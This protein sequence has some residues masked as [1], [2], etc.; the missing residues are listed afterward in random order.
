M[1]GKISKIK[2]TKGELALPVTTVEAVYLE[3]GKT[4]LSDEIKDVLKYEVIDDEGITA[5]I[6]SVIEEIDGIKK[7]IS[8]INSSLDTIETKKANK[9]DVIKKGQVDLDEMTERTLQAIQGGND[10]NFVLSSI[11]RDNSVD[12]GKL[13]SR[14]GK[15]FNGKIESFELGYIDTDGNLGYQAPTTITSNLIYLNAGTK[16]SVDDSTT[17]IFR[18]A[19]YVNDVLIER[20]QPEA[21][22]IT[23]A[24]SGYYK[25]QLFS[26]TPEIDFTNKLNEFV[27]K[28]KYD[29]INTIITNENIK[30][31]SKELFKDV[32]YFLN[33]IELNFTL[34]NIG[35]NGIFST[36]IT[37]TTNF[38]SNIINKDDFE[39][40]RITAKSSDYQVNYAKYNDGVFVARGSWTTDAVLDNSS[41]YRIILYYSKGKVGLEQI[42]ENFTFNI[43][44]NKTTVKKLEQEINSLKEFTPND[45]DLSYVGGIMSCKINKKTIHTSFDD[46]WGLLYKLQTE[47]IASIYDLDFFKFLKDMNTTYGATFTLNTFNYH[48][49]HT[50]YDISKISNKWKTEFQQAKKWLKFSFHAKDEKTNYN[51]S[52]G[53]KEDYIKFVN[54]IYHI[55]EDYECIDLFPRLGFFGGSLDQVEQITYD[56]VDYGIKGLLCADDTRLSYYLDKRKND[57][58]NNNS[59]WY[60]LNN[61]L[62][63]VKTLPRLDSYSANSIIHEAS[64]GICNNMEVFAHVTESEGV[65]LYQY[66]KTAI[67]EILKWAKTSGFNNDFLMNVYN[68]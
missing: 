40:I 15:Y 32:N 68:Y 22:E 17:V 6:P 10:T 52:K 54:A 4:K 64:K 63:C 65:T 9:E 46:C 37:G 44:H 66:Q 35:G 18:Y 27:L 33:G 47:N 31:Y 61:K 21:K 53:I 55:T 56:N 60:D 13:N 48:T 1:K 43:E 51:T 39:K 36:P 23:I 38:Y 7:D 5:E 2:N 26:R 8:E 50:D 42:L 41:D 59:I 12:E 3:D 14:I 20:H 19:R 28:M 49:G 25:I 24:T 57:C 58:V 11:P 62:V 45:I 29:Y 30:E 67:E 16:V 34:G